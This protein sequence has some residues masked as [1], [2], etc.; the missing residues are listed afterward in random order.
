MSPRNKVRAVVPIDKLP[1]EKRSVRSLERSIG[2]RPGVSQFFVSPALG[3]AYVEY[4]PVLSNLR[5][6]T[7]AV[8]RYV[9]YDPL[10]SNLRSITEA[11]QA[12]RLD[13]GGT[14]S[15]GGG[16]E[17]AVDRR[18]APESQ[19]RIPAERPAMVAVEDRP[20]LPGGKRGLP[21]WGTFLAM[22]VITS[23]ALACYLS[24]RPLI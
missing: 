21:G 11:I 20:A 19:V 24:V 1:G 3:K 10:L 23:F 4:D 18:A 14:R 13:A 9:E 17:I 22:F 6:I 8:Q 15:H 5:S 7:E 2:N 12:Y 16:S